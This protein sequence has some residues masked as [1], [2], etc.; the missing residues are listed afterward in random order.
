MPGIFK[1]HRLRMKGDFFPLPSRSKKKHWDLG[2]YFPVEEILERP[3]HLGA[4]NVYACC[5]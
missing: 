1:C 5:L 3:G 4:S 2:S